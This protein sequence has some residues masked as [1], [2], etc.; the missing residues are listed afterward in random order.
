MTDIRCQ[1]ELETDH[2]EEFVKRVVGG[3][4]NHLLNFSSTWKPRKESWIFRRELWLSCAS[5]PLLRE[6]TE[7]SL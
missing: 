6:G 1:S 5:R 4:I 7:K 3:P 2:P